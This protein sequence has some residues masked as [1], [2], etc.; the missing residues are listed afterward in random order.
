MINEQIS[1]IG[2]VPVVVLNNE[3][4]AVGLAKALVKGGL[5]T[6]EVTYR[7]DAAEGAIKRISKEVPEI[8]VGAGT[9][10]SVEMAKSAVNAGAKY[11]VS[12]GL[13]PKVVIWCLE[14]NIPIFPGVTCPTQIEQAMEL[15]LTT[16]KFFPAE[17]AG[18]IPMLKSF[19][20]PYCKM[21][22]MPTG[23]V[24]EKN[25]TDYLALKNV[26][27]CGG[28]WI[29]PT[30]LIDNEEF[31]K[32]E[33]LC[34]TAVSKMH[35]FKLL[36]V[37][38]NS[39]D[40]KEAESV[41]N[42]FSTMFNLPISDKGLAYFAGDMF[43]ICK[44]PYLGKNGHIA[45]GVHNINRAMAYF[46]AKGFNFRSEGYVENTLAYFEQEVGGFAIHLRQ[47]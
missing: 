37:G 15:G 17:A 18:G 45:I 29:C 6:A 38:V 41:A 12:P 7:T 9:I 3:E 22:F 1:N 11:L 33:D 42:L 43:E 36:H 21:K 10:T 4:N 13:N 25:V 26:I 19:A 40:E 24:S 5:P 27:A 2:I 39:N 23:G 46:K 32:I 14:N 28:S 35:G 16:V 47:L 8:L 30:K 31:D 20:S 34:K 44:T